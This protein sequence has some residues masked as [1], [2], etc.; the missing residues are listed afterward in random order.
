[1]VTHKTYN[2]QAT[3]SNL[4]PVAEEWLSISWSSSVPQG[5][6]TA[7]TFTEASNVSLQIH[8]SSLYINHFVTQLFLTKCYV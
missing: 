6:Y 2:Q 1:V 4:I 8:S 3:S 7:N 5:K